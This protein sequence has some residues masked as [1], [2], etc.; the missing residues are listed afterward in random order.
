MQVQPV[1]FPLQ[2]A[3]HRPVVDL[4]EAGSVRPL[5]GNGPTLTVSVPAYAHNE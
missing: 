4:P 5:A 2:L 1:V 3:G